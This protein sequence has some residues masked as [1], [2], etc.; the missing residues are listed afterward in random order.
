M[1]VTLC[2]E[3]KRQGPVVRS[4]LAIKY[5]KCQSTCNTLYIY[6]TGWLCMVWKCI[7]W[8]YL[9]WGKCEASLCQVKHMRHVRAYHT[10][11][12]ASI[13]HMCLDRKSR[14]HMCLDMPHP[15]SI[16]RHSL[17]VSL[18]CPTVPLSYRQPLLRA[19]HIKN[20]QYHVI[21]ERDAIWRHVTPVGCVTP[22]RYAAYARHVTPVGCMTYRISNTLCL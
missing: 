7:G 13:S 8:L 10:W 20:A 4:A 15:A 17:P 2:R 9:V 16:L 19:L 5:A 11:T 12:C 1:V 21:W 18:T 3:K 14:A 22:M 6:Q